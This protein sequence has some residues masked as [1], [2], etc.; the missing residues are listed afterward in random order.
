MRRNVSRV[1]KAAQVL[2]YRAA[3]PLE[4]GLASTA[5]WYETALEDR[6]LAAIRPHA[7]SGSE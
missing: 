5:R 3:I 1:E 4:G 6:E 7:A 2:G